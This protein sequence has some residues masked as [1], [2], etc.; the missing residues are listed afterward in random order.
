M[1]NTSRQLNGKGQKA[2]TEGVAKMKADGQGE[3]PEVLADLLRRLTGD[4]DYTNLAGISLEA[5]RLDKNTR[6]RHWEFLISKGLA[7][8]G[9]GLQTTPQQGW[10]APTEYNWNNP[11]KGPA[12]AE[13]KGWG[14][15]TWTEDQYRLHTQ[16]KGEEA[17]KAERARDLARPEHVRKAESA[18]NAWYNT[19][20]YKF[21]APY[22]ANLHEGPLAAARDPNDHQ[23][24]WVP[25]QL[26]EINEDPSN[27][28]RLIS[29]STKTL[30]QSINWDD[31]D[32]QMLLKRGGWGMVDPDGG[33]VKIPVVDEN[34]NLTGK[35][36]EQ[37]RMVVSDDIEL[38]LEY[39]PDTNR[40]KITGKTQ[41]ELRQFR[42]DVTENRRIARNRSLLELE[43]E[44]LMERLANAHREKEHKEIADY[45]DLMIQQADPTITVADRK[46][47]NARKGLERR[48]KTLV[49]KAGRGAI[50]DAERE[51]LTYINQTLEGKGGGTLLAQARLGDTSILG[52][53]GGR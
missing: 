51:E 17:I 12:I 46:I 45:I 41:E 14:F 42:V 36:E 52:G 44:D 37:A 10:A 7:K 3:D 24:Y 25:A 29:T 23:N 11:S 30:K 40:F 22:L 4:P 33:T 47:V 15:E 1:N 50:S 13:A 2:F 38:I 6:E 39:M 19:E 43:D 34:G 48:K 20:S 32:N 53:M 16:P 5:Y 35:V 31:P 9:A 28:N 49:N 18:N 8:K 21:L 27:P 26:S